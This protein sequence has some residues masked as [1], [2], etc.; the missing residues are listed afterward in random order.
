MM[1]IHALLNSSIDCRGL[2]IGN[3]HFVCINSNLLIPI[4]EVI[5]SFPFMK[6]YT[7]KSDV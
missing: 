6:L 5:A 4:T 1:S 2:G 3:S 7:W